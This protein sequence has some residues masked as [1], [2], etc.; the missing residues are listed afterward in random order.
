MEVPTTASDFAR[1]AAGH[2]GTMKPAEL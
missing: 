1:P 2:P